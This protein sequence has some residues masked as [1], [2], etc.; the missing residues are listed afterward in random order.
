MSVSVR[1]VLAD[2]HPIVRT[3]LRLGLEATS[4]IEV[5][6]EASDGESALSQ[7]QALSPDVAI[8]DIDMPKLD[9]LGVA[10][11]IRSLGLQVKI[12]LLTLHSE[13]IYL[14]AAFDAGAHGYIL[15]DSGSEDIVTAIRTVLSGQRYI[16]PSMTEQLI[17]LQTGEETIDKLMAKLTPAERNVM[18]LIAEGKASKEIGDELGIHYRTVDNHRT[19]IC[20]KLKIEGAN[21]L[22]R[23]A[24]QHKAEF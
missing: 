22:L 3:G 11:Q 2:D 10:R 15:K 1:V 8:L 20:R 12:I 5:V 16:G 14:R 17:S 7:I 9:G 23:F 19:N 24:L 6:G 13:A 21:S 4:G 18:R